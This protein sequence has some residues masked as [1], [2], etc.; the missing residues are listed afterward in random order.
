MKHFLLAFTLLVSLRVTAQ[1]S[2]VYFTSYPSL[3][4][5]AKTAVFSF[6]SDL[7]KVDLTTGVATRITAM[8]GEETNARFSPDGQWIA[9]S[10]TENG[11]SDVYV[12]S[13]TG[14]LIRQLTYHS[15]SDL[16]E[17]WSLDSKTI[18]FQSGSQNSGTTFKISVNG[19]TPERVFA[20]YFNRVHNVALAGD[21]IFFNDTWESLNQAMRKGYK[22]DFNPDI[23]SYNLKTKEYKKYT[24]YRG[25][26]MWPTI[27]KNGQV[28]FVSDE[29]NGNYNL[30]TFIN[31]KKTAL[32]QFTESIKRPQ[33][34]ADGSKVIF[35]KDYQL[36]LYDVASKQSQPLKLDL[37][38]NM[39]L[40]KLQDFDVKNEITAFDICPD[41]KKIAFT[42]RGQ[43]FVSDVK[44]KFVKQLP[45]HTD[46]RALEVKWLADSVTLLFSQTMGG[47]Q[48]LFTIAADG[49][50]KEKQ[51]TK[52]TQSNRALSLNKDKTFG[53][54]LSGRN[55]VRSL[56]LKTMESKTLLKEELWGLYNDTPLFSPNGEYILFTAYRD[57]ETDIFLHHIKKNETIN[58]SKTGVSENGPVWSPDSKYLYFTS[59][60]MN[61]SYPFGPKN[62]KVYRLGLTKLDEPFRTDKFDDLFKK[63]EKKEDKDDSKKDNKEKDAKKAKDSA[64]KKEEKPFVPIKIDMADIM[65]R[66]ELVSPSFGSQGTPYVI[67]KDSKTYIFYTSDHGEGKTAIWKTTY[68]PFETTKTEKVDDANGFEVAAA[69]HKYYILADGKIKTLDFEKGKTEA[70]D[71]SFTF[72]KNLSDEFNQMFY[73]AWA[74]VEENFYNESFHK[75]DWKALR[76]KYAGFLPYLT[77]RNDFRILF[78]DLLGELNASHL[79][80]RS[81]GKE[82]SVY[83]KTHTMET[84]L[85]FEPGKPYVIQRVVKRSAADKEDKKIVSGDVLTHVNGIAVDTSKNRD[86]YFTKPSSTREI[87]LKLKRKSVDTSYTVKIHPQAS[88][89]G[90]LYDEWIDWNQEYV[91]KNSKN[92][93]AYVHMKNMGL[94]EYDKFVVDMTRDWYKKDALIFDLR[95]NTGGNVHDLVLDFLARKPYMKWK[96]REGVATTQPNFGVAAKPIVLLIN[97]QSLSDAEV[98]AAG[99]KE[100]KLGK[101]IGTETYRW[102]IFTSG[103][104]LVDGSFY[105]LPAW[106]CYTLDGKNL[107]E[108][109]VT[110]DIYVKQTFSERL[111][112][113]D[114]QLQRAIDEIMKDLK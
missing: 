49:K 3:S 110:P 59:D 36:W 9:F 101:I 51:I 15:T 18:Y 100:L 75:A 48:N 5:D 94:A 39:T 97:E 58:L 80:L 71:V 98:T 61:P 26:D 54:Y 92:R 25:K 109:G 10:S 53:V 102:I 86:W 35:E 13:S 33:V 6:D 30:Y 81:T 11:N 65:D 106:G 19:G 24:D 29:H 70:I 74:G 46:G 56:D 41:N 112:D 77:S 17:A 60:R 63:E 38:R 89:N 52:D 45:T 40:P 93:I 12:V 31:K 44:G 37:M 105:R 83:Y 50:G 57:F 90:N 72:Q 43:L 96:Y 20:H 42:S 104:G 47:Y 107:E 79:G 16:V 78:N 67:Q 62:P 84:G 34:S 2:G 64:K 82:E 23:Q 103:K 87:E 91:D 8:Q 114:P 21:E 85:L 111:N 55:E 32:T 14:G 76:D 1:N 66:L 22:G 73:E 68:E 99:F 4:P 27:D 95:N 28:Y 69:D 7:W 108:E 88:L 113:V